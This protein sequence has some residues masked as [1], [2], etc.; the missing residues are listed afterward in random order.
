MTKIDNCPCCGRS[1]ESSVCSSGAY[2]KLTIYCTACGLERSKLVNQKSFWYLQSE[3][4]SMVLEWNT[5][6]EVP[7]NG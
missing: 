1:A 5:R 4:D 2:T 3:M 6:V 7:H